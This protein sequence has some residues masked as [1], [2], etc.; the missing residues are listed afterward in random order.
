MKTETFKIFKTD[1]TKE[2]K[3]KI[4]D[5]KKRLQQTFEIKDNLL[6]TYGSIAN[7]IFKFSEVIT[8][9]FFKDV[10]PDYLFSKCVAWDKNIIQWEYDE[11]YFYDILRQELS[12]HLFELDKSIFTFLFNVSH[13]RTVSD[14]DTMMLFFCQLYDISRDYETNI[15][16]RKYPHEVEEF[17][18]MLKEIANE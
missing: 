11:E 16:K 8:F 13:N 6:I 9:D 17:L 12:N 15:Y 18:K 5:D 1:G 3:A 2:L 7:A 14:Y 10:Y 4:Y